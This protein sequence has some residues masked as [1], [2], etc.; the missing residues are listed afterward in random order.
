MRTPRKGWIS[1][2]RVVIFRLLFTACAC[3]AP[4][5][6]ACSFIVTFSVL[7]FISYALGL[8]WSVNI[9]NKQRPVQSSQLAQ[10]PLPQQQR[11]VAQAAAPARLESASGRAVAPAI[12]SIQLPNPLSVPAVS[13]GARALR[14]N[15]MA[16]CFI[17]FQASPPKAR[18]ASF[19]TC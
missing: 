5:T 4:L 13:P 9:N 14:L 7:M 12:L 2:R 17:L 1:L 15:R 16:P 10:A 19:E 18:S 6:F 11:Q 3:C 8:S